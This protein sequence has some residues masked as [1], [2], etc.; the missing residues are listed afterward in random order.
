MITTKTYHSEKYG[1]FYL[2]EDKKKK[3]FIWWDHE[4][5]GD[6]GIMIEPTIEWVWEDVDIK[7]FS[8]A[9]KYG[10]FKSFEDAKAYIVKKFGKIK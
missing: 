8:D 3:V 6:E 1:Y 4:E 10:E 2:Q 9:P 7:D 5:V